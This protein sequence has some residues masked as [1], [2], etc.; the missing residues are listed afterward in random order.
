VCGHVSLI[1]AVSP[2]VKAR[3]RLQAATS[4]LH[5]ASVKQFAVSIAPS[6][7]LLAL[8]MQVRFPCLSKCM[9]LSLC[10]DP[11]YQVRLTFVMKL[12]TLLT[13]RKLPSTYNILLFMVIHDPE[14]DIINRVSSCM[15]TS[16]PTANAKIGEGLCDIRPPYNA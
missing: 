1:C 9:L 5:L 2:K 16:Y 6:F 10:K 7:V 3:L 15:G 14:A 4:L 8:E 11:C 13:A 12:V